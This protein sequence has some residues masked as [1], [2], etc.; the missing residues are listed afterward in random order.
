MFDNRKIHFQCINPSKCPA[1]DIH[2][3]NVDCQTVNVL[4]L[5][6]P[7]CNLHFC[8]AGQLTFSFALFAWQTLVGLAERANMFDLHGKETV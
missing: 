3:S 5:T 2:M 4:F 7:C 1:I 6:A 8:P